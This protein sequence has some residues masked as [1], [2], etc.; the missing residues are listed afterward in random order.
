MRLSASARASREFDIHRITYQHLSYLPIV[1][2]E[3]L[4][5]VQR[6][7]PLDYMVLFSQYKLPVYLHPLSEG[8]HDRKL[9]ISLIGPEVRALRYI[10]PLSFHPELVQQEVGQPLDRFLLGIL[11][12]Q[13][14]ANTHN[15]P[16]M[17]LE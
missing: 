16:N 13:D 1:L 4:E 2:D 5:A 17:Y 9:A 10:A 11:M 14:L 8:H 12:L 6:L 7:T 3:P 15:L